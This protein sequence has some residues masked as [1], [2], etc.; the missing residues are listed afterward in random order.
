MHKGVLGV[1]G[2]ALLGCGEVTVQQ[3][4]PTTGH[5]EFPKMTEERFEECAK[6]YGNQLGPGLWAFRPVLQV[7]QQGNVVDVNAGEVPNSAPDFAACT[8]IALRDMAI[9]SSVFNLRQTQST[10]STNEPTKEQR[11][12]VGNPVVVIVVVEIVYTE[13]IIEAGVG[14]ILFATTLQLVDDVA[15]AAKWKPKPT[16]NRCLDAAAGGTYMWEEF[17]RSMKVPSN[18]WSKTLESEQNKRGWCFEKFGN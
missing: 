8:R 11:S 3:P 15:E 2:L 16:K 12:L 6:L 9:P 4:H 5:P 17:C 18:C 10:A 14:A 13:V 7:N 1:V